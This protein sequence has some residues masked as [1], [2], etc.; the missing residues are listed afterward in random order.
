MSEPWH[1]HGQRDSGR[2]N[3]VLGLTP[4][5]RAAV[6]EYEAATGEL[7]R[8]HAGVLATAGQVKPVAIE[9]L[10]VRSGFRLKGAA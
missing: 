4:A 6:Q 3:A 10:L 2:W 7:C 5:Q 8:L 1:A 9:A